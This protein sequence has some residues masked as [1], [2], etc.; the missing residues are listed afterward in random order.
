M[1]FELQI[2]A[3]DGTDFVLLD[4]FNDETVQIRS[5]VQDIA[6]ISKVFTDFS[7]SFTIPAS[8]VNN[9]VFSYYY[10]NDLDEFNA[11]V[12]I[13]ARLEINRTSFRRGQIQLESAEIKNGEVQHYKITFYGDFVTLKDLIGNDKLKDLDYSSLSTVH[14]GAT[15]QTSITSTSN[16][17][18]RFPLI[19]SERVW[20]YTGGAS[21]DITQAAYALEWTELFPALKDAKILEFIEN[22]YGVTFTGNFLTNKRFTN[23]FTWWKNR[24]TTDF[25]S[26]PL[27]LTFDFSG[28]ADSS[29][30]NYAHLDTANQLDIVGYDPYTYP[31]SNTLDYGASGSL[32]VR[33]QVTNLSNSSPYYIDIYKNGVLYNSFSPPVVGNFVLVT[34]EQI[35][36]SGWSALNDTYTFKVRTTGAATF[37]YT[38]HYL[39][40]IQYYEDQAG[41]GNPSILHMEAENYQVTGSGTTV[42]AF[43]FNSTAPDMTVADWLSGTFKEFNLTCYPTETELEYQIEPLDEWYNSGED[44]DITPY[45][46][47]DSIEV[48]RPKLYNEINFKFQESKSLINEAYKEINGKDYGSLSET[49][50][51]YDGS[52]YEIN[53]PFETLLFSNI[54]STNGNLQVGYCLTKAPDYKPYVPKPIKLYLQDNLTPVSFVFDNGTTTPT[55]TNY[56]PFGQEVAYNNQDYTMNFGSEF[57]TL[58][59]TPKE[60]SLYDV[61]YKPYLI[62]L[63]RSK[64]RIVKCSAKFP[65]SL[66]TK[67]QLNDALIIRDKKYR[68]NEINTNMSTGEVKLVLIS[69]FIT[70]RIKF[71]GNISGVIDASGG[72]IVVPIKPPK[73]GTVDISLSEGTGFTT[74]NPTVP[75]TGETEKNWT[76]TAGANATGADR[77]DIYE[78]IIK[79]ENGD[80]VYTERI[81]VTQEGSS[82]FLLNED[83]G[84]ILTEDLFRIKL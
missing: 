30:P 71:I 18:V 75:A 32:T 70:G 24:E 34:N 83:G 53:L 72:V 21:T 58:D 54:D 48:E 20:S 78:Y 13:D 5:S 16:L 12:R 2:Y 8:K 36:T 9:Q 77:S 28:I 50:P 14:D 4:Q 19:S 1:K 41:F 69:D 38:I 37:D 79:D 10:N 61:Y 74:S 31:F 43:D 52:K 57:S 76:L 80:T 11:N 39:F 84:Y 7:Q 33:I 42:S 44:R 40:Q 64:T 45:V 60:K 3:K 26:Q 22:K 49:F 27:D 63:F 55:L 56:L 51:Q 66:I 46:I 59:N 62:N 67:L 17:D 29:S 47:T 25:T 82:D 73:G 6:D 65:I 68:I 23:S 35:F 15:V 81:V